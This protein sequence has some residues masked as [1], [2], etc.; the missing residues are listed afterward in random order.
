MKEFATL[1]LTHRCQL[2]PIHHR[3]R[4]YRSQQTETTVGEIPCSTCD[5]QRKV[6]NFLPS[7]RMQQLW[8]NK[9]Q[10]QS[11][12]VRASGRRLGWNTLETNELVMND[13]AFA[14][15]GELVEEVDLPDAKAKLAIL[16][17]SDILIPGGLDDAHLHTFSANTV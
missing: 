8:L 11:P 4:L 5:R 10:S 12:T 6:L 2:Y 16:R 7:H 1:P 15:V 17:L 13:A 14:I 3:W 9:L